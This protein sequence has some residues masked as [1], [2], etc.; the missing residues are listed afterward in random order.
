MFSGRTVLERL[1][2]NTYKMLSDLT[3]ECDL[4]KITIKR[5]MHTD[6]ASIPQIFWSIIG[7]PLMGKYVGSALIH[8]GLYASKILT[9][10]QSDKLFEQMM[11][12]NNVGV[13]RRKLMYA[14]VRLGGWASW[15]AYTEEFCENA[16]RFIDVRVK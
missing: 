7:S 15:N 12:D 5:G 13:V 11:K 8:D 2:S 1:N 16:R 3:F 4:Y 9:R 10:K 6:G 14:A